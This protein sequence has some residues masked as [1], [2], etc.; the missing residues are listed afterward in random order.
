[1]K[2]EIFVSA[3][4]SLALVAARPVN[5]KITKREVPQE[6]SH[7]AILAVVRTSLN[8]NNPAAIKDPVFGLLGNAVSQGKR[9]KSRQ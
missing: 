9:L 7:N 2:T 3:L 5:H 4:V 1:M 8:T 6:H